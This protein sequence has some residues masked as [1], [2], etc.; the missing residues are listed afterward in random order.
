MV[1]DMLG[2]SVR[3]LLGKTYPEHWSHDYRFDCRDG[4]IGVALEKSLI[5]SLLK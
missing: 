5:V 2:M 4:G 1:F 3:G